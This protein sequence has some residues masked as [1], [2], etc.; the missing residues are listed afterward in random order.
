MKSNIFH[1]AFRVNYTGITAQLI[2]DCAISLP[3]AL[4]Q[5][6]NKQFHPFKALWDTGATNSVI[7]QRIVEELSTV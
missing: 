4:V 3:S 5:T 2:T 1:H 7:T 6:Q